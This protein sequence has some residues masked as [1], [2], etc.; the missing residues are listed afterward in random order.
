MYV[1]VLKLQRGNDSRPSPNLL[2][3]SRQRFAFMKSVLQPEALNLKGRYFAQYCRH[4][5]HGNA[6]MLRNSEVDPGSFWPHTYWES[7][8]QGASDA[9]LLAA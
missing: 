6:K 3:A 4:G 1:R 9:R 8:S 2:L 5:I 7:I